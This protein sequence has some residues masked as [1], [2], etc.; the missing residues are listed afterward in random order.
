MIINKKGEDEEMHSNEF[1]LTQNEETFDNSFDFNELE[2]E[3]ENQLKVELSELEFLKEEQEK[4]GN[5]DNLGKVIGDVIWEQFANQIGLDI[6]DET[7]IQKYDREH[8]EGYE[9][10]GKQVMKDKV[11]IATKNKM[12]QQQ[13]NGELVDAYTGIEFQKNDKMNVD[14]VIPRKKLFDNARRKQAGLSVKQ[15]ANKAENLQPTNESLNKSK[16]EK[17]NKEYILKRKEREND[18][19]KANEIANKKIENS[20]LSDL[21]K[22]SQIKKNNKRLQDKLN[23]NPDKM[24]KVQKKA[25]NALN[26]DIAIGAVKQVG[27]KAGKDALKVIAISALFTL[28]KE[29]MNG[30]VRFF[31]S[32]EKS[33]DNF[34]SEMKSSIKGFFEKILNFI[35]AGVS[36][37]IGT[38][39]SE[40]FGPIVSTIRKLASIIKQS[41]SSI[42]EAMRYLLDKKNRN[43]SFPVKIMQV[44]KII[45]T[46]LT[47]IVALGLGEVIEKGLEII[48]PALSL[49]QIP[50]LGS[51]ANIIGIF[52][53][54]IVSG[55]IGAIAIHFIQKTIEKKIKKEALSK[56]IDRGNE[57]LVTQYKIQKVNEEKLIYQKK[58]ITSNIENKHEKLSKYIVEKEIEIEEK[59]KIYKEELEKYKKDTEKNFEKYLV[60][61][62]I[63]ISE[64]ERKNQEKI[65]KNFDEIDSLLNSLID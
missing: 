56:Q 32:K 31:K 41:V 53:G 37:L 18:L 27:K 46:G 6:T 22:K 47:G 50:L 3:L 17:T 20:N 64:E 19:I 1:A 9:E 35:Q 15:L 62:I 24:L 65:E 7:L 4:I 23:A 55:I 63:I 29:I 52:M 60:E 5:P 45:I 10:V 14:H 16:G 25:E 40:I 28:L 26:K 34:L 11:Y 38:I 33:I 13:Q 43:I 57:V 59:N 21:E 44:G 8:P 36:N 2:E 49:I 54:A 61:N 39:I 30:L 58:Q 12:K 48:L 42:S 51:L